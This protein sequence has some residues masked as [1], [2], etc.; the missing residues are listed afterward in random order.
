MVYYSNANVEELKYSKRGGG[1]GC[2]YFLTF[3]YVGATTFMREFLGM[4]WQ[5]KRREMAVSGCFAAVSSQF[6]IVY[7]YNSS[8]QRRT[9]ELSNEGCYTKVLNMTISAPPP[10]PPNIKIQETKP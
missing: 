10:N 6:H 2:Y 9:L 4:K 3:L 7:T 8:Y 1:G 5:I